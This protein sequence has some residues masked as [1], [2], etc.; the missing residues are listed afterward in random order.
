MRENYI[1]RYFNKSICHFGRFV[2][3]GVADISHGGDGSLQKDETDMRHKHFQKIT[4]KEIILRQTWVVR[5]LISLRGGAELT[6]A[7]RRLA[8]FFGKENEF[9]ILS[10]RENTK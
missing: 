9:R 6:S 4:T 8:F 1:S 2:A 3:F 5:G 10:W 7:A